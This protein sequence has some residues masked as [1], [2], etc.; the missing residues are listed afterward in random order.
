MIRIKIALF[1]NQIDNTHFISMKNMEIRKITSFSQSTFKSIKILRD[2]LQII[3]YG[4]IYN[5]YTRVHDCLQ[6]IVYG[7]IYNYYTCVH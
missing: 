5:Y 7:Y 4:Y 6:I 2:C 1:P 3:V